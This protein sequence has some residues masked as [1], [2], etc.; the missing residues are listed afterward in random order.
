[1]Q[2]EY[3]GQLVCGGRFE[4][5]ERLGR[6]AMGT[7]WRAVDTTLGREV[8]LKEM[9]IPEDADPDEAALSRARVLREAR[10][11]ARL[12]NPHIVT[13]H[14]VVD[15]GPAP[16]IVME[17][18]PG[19][20]MAAV[21][22]TGPLAPSRAA[23]VGRD[24]LDA[25]RAAHDAE[26]LHRDVKPANVLI[27]PDGRAV[28]VDF[29]VASFSGATGSTLT[30][31]FVGTLDYLAPERA[32]GKRPS[33]ASDLWSLGVLLYT[34]V[35]GR[36][37]FRREDEWLTL[38]AI[39]ND[40]PPEPQRAG[41]LGPVILDLLAKTPEDRPSGA[42][43][44][45]RLAAIGPDPVLDEVTS[46]HLPTR[47]ERPAEPAE[48]T[49]LVV[50]S[51]RAADVPTWTGPGTPAAA[52]D[53]STGIPQNGSAPPRGR[54]RRIALV[55]AL[56]GVLL[57]GGATAAVL[58]MS[59]DDGSPT[60]GASTPPASAPPTTTPS[61]T[62]TPAPVLPLGYERRTHPDGFAVAVPKGWKEV[63]DSKRPTYRSPDGAAEL[64]VAVHRNEADDPLESQSRSAA[65]TKK[66]PDYPGYQELQLQS[67][68]RDGGPSATW[69][70]TYNSAEGRRHI[71]D[72]RWRVGT[73]SYNVWMA[74]PESNW[75]QQDDRL[76]VAL[77]HFTDTQR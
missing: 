5:V 47:T 70:Y 56:V 62:P 6:G 69:E 14:E 10:A 57:A 59:G 8:A 49:T 44:A 21:L 65:E 43:A 75:T 15:E 9:R 74:A 53:P 4:L 36:S 22:A 17:L 33:P 50:S 2:G 26:V 20:S 72:V 25:L 13:V 67:G 48:P 42:D 61:G 63:R 66:S 31:S 3:R 52:A 18:I 23:A 40:P 27:R 38:S 68:T 77:Q 16:W 30:S 37:P 46:L 35:E 34:A 29:G 24:V 60:A 1:M 71:K 55:G 7:V 32:A 76:T 73:T 58:T 28:L 51:R 54:G 12:R 64:V 41:S 19:R 11:L 45:D 39:A